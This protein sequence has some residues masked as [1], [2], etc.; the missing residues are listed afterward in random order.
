MSDFRPADQVSIEGAH[1]PFISKLDPA[2]RWVLLRE[3]IPW[4]SLERHY[5]L[6][7]GAS[8]GPPIKSFQMALAAVYIQQRL[9]VTDQ[10]TV[11]LITESPYLQFFIGLSSYQ[12]MSPFDSSMMEQFR[13]HLGPD[14][15]KICKEMTKPSGIARI[16]KMLA[17]LEETIGKGEGDQQPATSAEVSGLGAER[18]EEPGSTLM[19]DATSP[20]DD[21]PYLVDLRLLNEARTVTETIID[22][23]FKQLKGKV[24]RKPRCG[25]DMAR[26]HFLAC[27]KKKRL[28]G[29]QIREAKRF[30][31]NEISRNLR[32]ID[33][34]ICSGA[35][36]SRLGIQ[37]YRK[38]LIA[39]EV[40]RQ[41]RQMVDA[42]TVHIDDRIVNL[43]EPHVRHPVREKMV[44]AE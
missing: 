35:V 30:Q 29:P 15:L 21:I 8:N 22:E 18:L 38:L 34:L 37:L 17:S 2:N 9:G 40:Y 25:R 1:V 3:L 26:N 23:L 32:A 33:R 31:L 16:T 19:L 5:P 13:A 20:S 41:Q 14:L 24:N 44:A 11:E 27:I 39:S 4:M 36:L 28:K 43:S 10:E 6:Q 42:N 12:A 7:S